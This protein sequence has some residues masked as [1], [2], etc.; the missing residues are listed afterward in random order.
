LRS[1][2]KFLAEMSGF[3]EELFNRLGIDPCSAE[4]EDLVK[5]AVPSDLLRGEGYKRFLIQQVKS[6]S[7]IVFSSSGTTGNTPVRVYRTYLELAVMTRA[8]T[9]LFEYVYG[10]ELERGR[11]IALFLAAK[12]LRSRLNFVAFDDL[13]LQGK[14]IPLLYSLI[15]HG[16]IQGRGRRL[17]IKEARPQ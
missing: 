12:E 10:G 2:L 7:S 4:L 17:S 13:T 11:G 5:L 1:S 15:R 3:Y 16:V 9:L 14:E 8:N 6:E